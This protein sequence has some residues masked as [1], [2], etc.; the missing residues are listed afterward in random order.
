MTA[1]CHYHPTE[2][3]RWQCGQC[4]RFYCTSCM[5]EADIK[6]R[7]GLCPHCNEALNYVDTSAQTTPFWEQTGRFFRYP[8]AVDPLA[9]VILC[10]LVPLIAPHS[11]VGLVLM[12]ILAAAMIRYDYAAL[13]RTAEGKMT[14]PSLLQ[15]FSRDGFGLAFMQFGLFLAMGGVLF[16]AGYLGGGVLAFIA[17][18]FMALALPASIMTLA[19]ERN[20]VPAINPLHLVSLMTRIGWPYLVLYGYLILLMLTAGIVEDF[21]LHHFPGYVGRGLAGMVNSYFIL[22]LFH[23]LGYCLYQYRGVLG[24]NEA[25]DGAEGTLP[26]RQ[27]E[28]RRDADL[29]MALKDGQYDRAQSLILDGLRQEPR[30]S[31]RLQQLYR[32]LKARDDNAELYRQQH[33]LLPWLLDQ[34]DPDAVMDYLKRLVAADDKFRLDDPE[35]AFRCAETAF[36]LG[37][38]RWVL[39]LLRDFHKRFPKYEDLAR[40]YL[41][42]ARTLANGLR[43]WDKAA[44]F[45]RFVQ[46]RCGDHPASQHVDNYL[47]LVAAHKPIA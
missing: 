20:L 28:R 23:L 31:L 39:T 45:L 35:L 26:A 30:N 47:A 37:E 9:I 43:Q 36:N 40:A 14:P 33:R 46:Q 34:Q 42:V 27:P 6:R 29:D 16:L 15:A 11:I 2:N 24:L 19:L 22:I 7:R 41:L 4:Q 13:S 18:I 1:Y 12:L 44:A 8:L 21:A 10:T 5:P 25:D 32:L 38:Y 3:A 17:L